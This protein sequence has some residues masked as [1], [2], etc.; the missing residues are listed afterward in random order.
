MGAFGLCS[1]IWK[2]NSQGPKLNLMQV[3]VCNRQLIEF[4][5]IDSEKMRKKHEFISEQATE[6][7]PVAIPQE[8]W[9]GEFNAA[10]EPLYTNSLSRCI[11]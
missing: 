1:E 11:N 3:R 6:I 8:F 10:A 2:K 5:I 7:E 9:V 4:M